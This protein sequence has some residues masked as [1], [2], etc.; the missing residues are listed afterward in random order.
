MPYVSSNTHTHTHRH[1]RSAPGFS[2][3]APHTVEPRSL[4]KNKAAGGT[5]RPLPPTHYC[6]AL[7]SSQVRHTYLLCLTH[8]HTERELQLQTHCEVNGQ[9][10]QWMNSY[11]KA[12]ADATEYKLS[13]LQNPK[14]IKVWL[15]LIYRDGPSS[16]WP[17]DY[18]WPSVHTCSPEWLKLSNPPKKLE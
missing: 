13:P 17:L 2:T 15:A 16:C 1:L 7:G 6:T 12:I 3:T 9:S 4:S 11:M 18:R 8:T 5:G 14:H 10:Y